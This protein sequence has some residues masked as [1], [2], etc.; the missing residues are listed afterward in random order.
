MEA[1][2]TVVHI[3][4]P[5]AATNHMEKDGTTKKGWFACTVILLS[6]KRKKERKG[7][8]KFISYY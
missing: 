8:I 1:R 2:T 4:I 7:L 5:K 6:T 3:C